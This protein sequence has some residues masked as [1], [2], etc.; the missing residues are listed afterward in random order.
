MIADEAFDAAFF[1]DG[2]GLEVVADFDAEGGVG[3]AGLRRQSMVEAG[4]H[5]G[6]AVG[7]LAFFEFGGGG[8]AFGFGSVFAGELGA[9]FLG[10]VFAPFLGLE[11]G[12]ALRVK[13]GPLRRA[14]RGSIGTVAFLFSIPARGDFQIPCRLLIGWE[15]TLF[16]CVVNV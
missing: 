14:V 12:K 9:M 4:A 7:G 11:I 13:G 5:A 3:F 10:H 2:A 1:V 6:V 8:C 15:K 16:S